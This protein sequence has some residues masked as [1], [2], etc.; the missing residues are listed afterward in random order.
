MELF[1]RNLR[2]GNPFNEEFLPEYEQNRVRKNLELN[3][4]LRQASQRKTATTTN[5]EGIIHTR[6][7]WWQ[8][9][10]V[11]RQA[12]IT[13]RFQK[14]VAQWKKD[15]AFL[16]SSTDKFSHPAY[17]KIIGLGEPAVPL[18]LSEMKEY[19]GQWFLALRSIT[20]ADPVNPED[21]GKIK[22][23]AEAWLQWGVQNGYL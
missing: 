14:L 4:A 8:A 5:V 18:I 6:S 9:P 2:S 12:V 11:N 21:V 3:S 10:E 16:S 19:G 20:D 22:K 23:M 15:T 13:E 1:G 7:L 17:L